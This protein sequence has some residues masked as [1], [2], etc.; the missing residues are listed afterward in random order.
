MEIDLAE[1][2]KLLH[3]KRNSLLYWYPIVKDVAPT[4]KTAW[5]EVKDPLDIDFDE[6]VE[7]VHELALELGGYPVF[8]RTD[9]FSGK[10]EFENTCYVRS[11][12]TLRNNLVNLVDFSFAH[13]LPLNAIV[14]REYVELDWKFKAFFG[15]LPIAP[16]VRVMIK[17]HDID[18]WFFYWPEDAIRHP[19]KEN[20][21][22][23]LNEMREIARSEREIFCKIAKSV[24]KV[25]DGYWSVDFARTKKGEWILIDMALGEVSWRPNA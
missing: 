6:L 20:W 18:E 1:F 4:P 9:H 15:R 25:L 3:D 17:D 10:H 11:K 16:E 2:L 8:V 24:A 13:D 7:K 19:D 12:E 5:V 21:R 14:V 23:L 22:E